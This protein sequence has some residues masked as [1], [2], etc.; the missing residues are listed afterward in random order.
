MS[1]LPLS[2]TWEPPS[3]N[4][5]CYFLENEGMSYVSCEMIATATTADF[6][7]SL[8]VNKGWMAVDPSL[9]NYKNIRD[10]LTLEKSCLLWR[11]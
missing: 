3:R 8:A 9:V 1:L 4:V 6:S 10:E 5:N 7:L 2:E 11:F